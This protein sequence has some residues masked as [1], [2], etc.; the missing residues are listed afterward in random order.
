[1]AKG[2]KRALVAITAQILAPEPQ[3]ESLQNLPLEHH[4]DPPPAMDTQSS[5]AQLSKTFITQF[6]EE[7]VRRKPATHLLTVTQREDELLK[8]YIIRFN[9]KAIQVDD[10]SDQIALAVMIFEELFS[11]RKATWSIDISAKDIK[12]KEEREPPT[13]NNKKRRD[14]ESNR[15]SHPNRRSKSRFHSYTPLNT[16][17]EQVF[18]EVCDKRIM[19][20]SSR[21]KADADKRDKRKYCQFH[22]DHGHT[23]TECFDLNKEI[24]YLIRSGH[25]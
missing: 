25:L 23:T 5:F 24:E 2:K 7:K 10:Y 12:R 13:V 22:R 6:I 4:T 17:A 9:E 18:M 21:M 11:S 8:D 19:K 16:T 20:R 1:M 3:L 15:G 14:D